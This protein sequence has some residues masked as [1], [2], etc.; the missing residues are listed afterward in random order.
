[1]ITADS[2]VLVAG[3]ASWHE[4]HAPARR[5]LAGTRMTGHA[6]LEAYSVLTR[7]PPPHRAPA[8]VA[9]AFLDHVTTSEPLV[10]SAAATRDLPER[11]AALGVSGGATYDALIAATALESDAELLS[12]DVRAVTTYRSMA[13]RHRLIS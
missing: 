8:D 12:L 10:L 4:L 13:V 6:L 1:M 3:F 2:S 7:L 11:L 5:A 9:A